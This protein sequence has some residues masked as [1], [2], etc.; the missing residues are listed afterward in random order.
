VLGLLLLGEV[1][2]ELADC[3]DEDL[4]DA[5]ETVVAGRVTIFVPPNTPK[6]HNKLSVKNKTPNKAT[7][8]HYHFG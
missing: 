1:T 3:F 8:G 6:P 4:G 7:V 2:G 5:A